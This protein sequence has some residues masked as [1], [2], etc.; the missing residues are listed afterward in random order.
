MNLDWRTKLIHPQVTAPEGF[1]SL[2][3]PTYRGSTTLFASAAKVTD[4]WDQTRMHYSYGLYGTPTS[5]E[6]AARVV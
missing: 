5:L 2:V 6:L 4:D 1:R 3:T